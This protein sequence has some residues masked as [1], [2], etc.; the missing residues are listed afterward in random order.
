MDTEI[1]RAYIDARCRSCRA[2]I[3]WHGT[4]LD[5]PACPRCGWKPDPG[6]LAAA[7]R[8]FQADRRLLRELAAANP[9][10]ERWREARLAAGLTLRQAA[11]I[12]EI[13]PTKLSQVEQGRECPS[14][15]LA[16]EMA[17]FYGGYS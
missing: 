12:L 10:W 16:A 6:Q 9:G 11:K 13:A 5:Q 4:M 1:E 8:R 2:R 3:G 14:E 7:H 17:R 15:S